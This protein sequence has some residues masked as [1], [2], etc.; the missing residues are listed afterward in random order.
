MAD[1]K[2]AIVTGTTSGIGR[3][4]VRGLADAGYTVVAHARNADKAAAELMKLSP[5]QRERVH[6]VLADLSSRADVKRLAEELATRFPKIDLLIHNAAVVPKTRT[7]TSDQLDACFAANVLAPFILT[8]R[9]EASLRAAA[10]SRVLFYWGGGQDT[11]D[12]GDLQWKKRTPYDG[13]AA[14]CQS[15]NA[16][17][18]LAGELARRTGASG[19]SYFIVLP[20]LVNTE[21]MQGLGNLFSKLGRPFFRTPAQGARTP[22]WVAQERGLEARSGACFGSL[23][24]SGWRNEMKLSPN[25]RDPQLASRLF[26]TC[27]ELAG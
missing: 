25:A 6:T 13:W 17:A 4:V 14:Y 15:K 27:E 12:V 3:E 22:L 7:E 21:G 5:S 18:L 19:V 23:L 24:G 8:K 10:P 11:F 26:G 2:V 1:T 9:L 16:C 20:G